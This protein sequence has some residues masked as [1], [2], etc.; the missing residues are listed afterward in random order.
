M[1]TGLPPGVPPYVKVFGPGGNCTLDICPVE[2]SVYGYRPSLAA[3][4]TFLCL[5]VISAS[6]HI[7]LGVRWRTWFFMGC[8]VLGAVNAVLGYAGRIAMYYNPFNF[9]AFMIQII[10]V[11]SGPVYYSA[12]IYVTLAAA[13]KHLSPSLSRFNPNLFY[14]TFLP[15]DIIC[16]IFQAAGGGL[17]TASSGT[18]QIGVDMALVGLSLQVASMVIFCGFFADYLTRY[19]N[20]VAYKAN[21]GRL[22]NGVKFGTRLKLFY[23]FMTLAIALILARCAYRLVELREGYRGSLIHNEPLFIGLEGVLVIVAVYCLMIAHPGFVFKKDQKERPD[24]WSEGHELR[25]IP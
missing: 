4:V 1:S 25:S 14:W 13:I 17:S 15:S 7:Y 11:T 2:I 21:T 8:M 3:N 5:Y 12:A 9:A 23:S 10:C 24:R 16:L 6:I 22:V 20:S 18:S 19:F